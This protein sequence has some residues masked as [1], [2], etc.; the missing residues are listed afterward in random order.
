MIYLT[1]DA[2]LGHCLRMKNSLPLCHMWGTCR[3]CHC[4]TSLTAII[5]HI[6]KSSRDPNTKPNHTNEG[7]RADAQVLSLPN[8]LSTRRIGLAYRILHHGPLWLHGLIQTTGDGTKGW[9]Q[10]LRKDFAWRDSFEPGELS[11]FPTLVANLGTIMNKTLKARV[12]RAK[13]AAILH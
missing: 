6:D 5:P 13:R 8:F 12:N 9:T 7:V 1:D 4:R 10:L 3:V 2:G 11:P